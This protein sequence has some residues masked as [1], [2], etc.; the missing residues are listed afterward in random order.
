MQHQSI[1]SV[2]T[3]QQ[4]NLLKA[5]KIANF[6]KPTALCEMARLIAAEIC[7]QNLTNST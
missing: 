6:L 5:I 4:S 2:S 3:L 7:T 1:L